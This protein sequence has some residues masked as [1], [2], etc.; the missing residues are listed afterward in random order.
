MT[1]VDETVSLKFDEAKKAEEDDIRQRH[2]ELQLNKS[3]EFYEAYNSYLLSHSW[4]A[5]RSLVLK[6]AGGLCEGCGTKP[7][8]QVHHTSYKHLYDE[9]LFELV[10]V[11][12]SC[13]ERLHLEVASEDGQPAERDDEITF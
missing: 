5:K 4:Q 9:F 10:A 2:I 6:R 12:D 1:W 11:C 13:H 3:S 7:A 8:T